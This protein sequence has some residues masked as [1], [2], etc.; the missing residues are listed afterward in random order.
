M[1][2]LE[3]MPGIVKGEIA[4]VEARLQRMAAR[5]GVKNWRKLER[6]LREGGDDP[7][8]DML[9]PEYLYLRDLLEELEKQ[10]NTC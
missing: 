8:V 6:F 9:W 3:I 4:S 1:R 7:E 2:G 10:D 5:L